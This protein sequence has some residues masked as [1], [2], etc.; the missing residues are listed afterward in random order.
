MAS[1][2]AVEVVTAVVVAGAAVAVV[3]TVA[4]VAV[5]VA[6]VVVA[7]DAAVLG[8]AAVAV[9]VA[10]VVVAAAMAPTMARQRVDWNRGQVAGALDVGALTG[11]D[12]MVGASTPDVGCFCLCIDRPTSTPTHSSSHPSWR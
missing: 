11:I 1:R 7:T 5:A 6:T 9:A 10:A 12:V 8:A 2:A 4:A 3:V